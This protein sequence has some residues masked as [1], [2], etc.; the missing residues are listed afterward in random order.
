MPFQGHEDGLYLIKQDAV[1][2]GIRVDH[3]GIL[4][5][6]NTLLHEGADGSHPIVL[7]QTPPRLRIDWLQNTGTWTVLGRIIDV[8]G[9]K[10]RIQEAAQN[11]DYNLFG[12]NCEHF[13]RFVAFSHNHSTQ[14]FWGVVGVTT[15][16]FLTFALFKVFHDTKK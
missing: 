8:E 11:P 12:N 7:H 5:I 1:K 9:A 15:V 10:S 13:A 3:Y 4:D 16:G 14:I 6:G 2:D